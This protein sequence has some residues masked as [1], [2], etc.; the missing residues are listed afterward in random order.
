[1]LVTRYWCWFAAT[2]TIANSPFVLSASKYERTAQS[3]SRI[4]LAQGERLLATSNE[5]RITSNE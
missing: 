2:A 1:L 4:R 3:R 5:Q